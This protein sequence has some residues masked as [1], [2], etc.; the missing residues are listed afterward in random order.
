[1]RCRGNPAAGASGSRGGIARQD[2]NGANRV[3]CAGDCILGGFAPQQE[4][5]H[6]P[7]RGALAQEG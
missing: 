3:P 4:V 6:G 7:M 5:P 2:N 1:M